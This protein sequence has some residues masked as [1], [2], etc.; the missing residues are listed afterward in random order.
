[1]GTSAPDSVTLGT[2]W[3]GVGLSLRR[4]VG[5]A[6]ALCFR[7]LR[8][9]LPSVVAETACSRLFG[10]ESVQLQPLRLRQRGVLKAARRD[11]CKRVWCRKHHARPATRGFQPATRSESRAANPV[12]APP[13]SSGNVLRLRPALL[14]AAIRLGQNQALAG[15]FRHRCPSPCPTRSELDARNTKCHRAGTLTRRWM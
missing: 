2:G 14:T 7:R 4:R 13:A 6:S 15:P 11:K 5:A 12:P 10:F 9:V 3:V 8:R 1:M